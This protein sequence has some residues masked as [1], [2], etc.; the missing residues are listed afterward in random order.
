[1]IQK[2]PFDNL[3]GH[4]FEALGALPFEGPRSRFQLRAQRL[5]GDARPHARQRA[6][7]R[8]VV[9][10][11]AGVH[12]GWKEDVRDYARLSAGKRLRSDADNLKEV[13]AHLESA[14]DHLGIAPEAARP[15]FVR[16]HGVGMRPRLRIVIGGEQ[17]AGRRP[18]PEGVEHPAGDVLHVSLLHLR[19]RLVGQIRRHD[20]GGHGQQFGLPF[21]R[22]P[23][24]LEVRIR[25][26]FGRRVFPVVGRVRDL[27]QYRI[28]LLWR[29]HGQRPQKYRV[30]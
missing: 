23:H 19:V 24:Q 30:D 15:V 8:H 5:H 12:H 16:E 7:P 25:P 29:R 2:V 27:P 3:A 11:H 22:V 13:L 17:A 28:E 1:M 18:Q 21:R 26:D 4:V 6:M 14:A 9:V 20:G 10:G